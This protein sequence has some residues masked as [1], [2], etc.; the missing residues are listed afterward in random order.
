MMIVL[1]LVVGTGCSDLTSPSF[2]DPSAEEL[3]GSPNRAAIGGAAMGLVTQQRGMTAS[4]IEVVGIFGREGYDL[5]P[6]EPR[7]ITNRLIDPL[8]GSSAFW[9]AQYEQMQNAFVLLAA[10]EGAESDILMAAE[11]SAASGFVK[12][13]MAEAIYEVA[14]MHDAQGAGGLSALSIPLDVERAPTDELAPL[15]SIDAA[16]QWAFDMF[17]EAAADLGSAGGAFPFTLPPGFDGFDTPA[18]FLMANRALKVRALKYQGR[19]TDVLST[20]PQTFVDAQGDLQ[21]GVYFDYSTQSGD[22]INEFASQRGTNLWAHPRLLRDAELR[23]NGEKDLRAQQKL[24]PGDGFTLLGITVSEVFDLY[25]SLS[26]P[27][28][29]IQ[30]EELVLIRAEANLAQGN[31]SA[32]IEDI[33]TIRERSGGLEPISDPFDGDLLGQL[34]YEKR[35]SLMWE[36]GF[37]YL[38][39]RQYDRMGDTPEELPRVAD[40]HVVYPR[41]PYP[42]NECIARGIESDPGCQPVFGF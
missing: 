38:D 25:V 7:T 1:A 29:W 26:D 34:L 8:I 31:T 23:G 39:A 24:S 16:Y 41:Y 10:I 3:T 21:A 15:E 40:N 30:N 9:E 17:D 42:N 37:T 28:P 27:I 6:E 13:F 33:N 19:W 22:E 12:T 4:F 32:A 18:T 36:G 2:N 11:K 14:L 20:L 5:R 35:Y